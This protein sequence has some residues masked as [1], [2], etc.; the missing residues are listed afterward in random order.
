MFDD[1]LNKVS[2]R[3][4]QQGSPGSSNF[5]PNMAREL[6]LAATRMAPN[7]ERAALELFQSSR[8]SDLQQREKSKADAQAVKLAEISGNSSDNLLRRL[9]R[10]R[11]SFN[12][13]PNASTIGT[14]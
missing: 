2:L 3:T 11:E 4:G 8:D 5:N 1:E 14:I 12:S 9:L 6:S 13:S 7:P 10:E